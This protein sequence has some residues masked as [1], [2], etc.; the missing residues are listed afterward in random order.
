MPE[1][2]KS[3]CFRLRGWID[4]DGYIRT[5]YGRAV[6]RIAWER[7]NG[8]IPGGL[9]IDHLCRNR[10]C[11]NVDHMELVTIRENVLRG[12]GI[13]AMNARKT[14]CLRGH[15][16]SGENLKMTPDGRRQCRACERWRA[17][18]YRRRQ[19]EAICV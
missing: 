6:H 7:A 1:I 15:P 11:A 9:Q 2:D 13:S 17:S 5:S 18:S 14:H 16:L 19:M 8:P 3:E 10:W 12:M 4:Q